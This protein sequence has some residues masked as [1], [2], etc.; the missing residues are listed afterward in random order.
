MYICS[1]TCLWWLGLQGPSN[2]MSA[3]FDKE[4]RFDDL[5]E[6]VIK[7]ADARRF[8][9]KWPIPKIVIDQESFVV[10][11]PKRQVG[12][13]PVGLLVY[14]SPTPSGL[15]AT[16]HMTSQELLGLLE[17]HRLAY[18]GANNA[19]NQRNPLDRMQLALTGVAGMKS[20]VS[21]DPE[22]IVVAG[23]SGGGKMAAIAGRYAPDLFAGV[24]S[25]GGV[26]FHRKIP[27]K[28][29]RGFSYPVDMALAAGLE[30]QAAA[31]V[32]FA[33]VTGSED[34]NR[35][36]THDIGAAYRKAGFETMLIDVDGLGHEIPNAETL[37]RCLQFVFAKG[38]D[39]T[40]PALKRSGK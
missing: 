33:L 28:E 25:I 18:V 4:V 21:I 39:R 38:A 19:Q 36:P 26:S 7:A 8:A 1:I 17:K 3:G 9:W 16:R 23:F 11:C 10:H 6:R 37:D 31:K 15:M 14:M 30:K 22:R 29:K 34:F 13:M 24:I 12:D 20:R 40:Q 5:G 2:G 32:R 35:T 27:V